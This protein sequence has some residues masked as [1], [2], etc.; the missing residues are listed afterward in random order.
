MA[1]GLW[2]LS[3]LATLRSYRSFRP[4]V[5]Y[6]WGVSQFFG[7]LWRVLREEGWPVAHN[8]EDTHV[9]RQIEQ[10]AGRWELWTKPG[11]TP[12][13]GFVKKLVRQA[14]MA[15]DSAALRPLRASEADLDHLVFCSGFI[16]DLH[17]Q[18]GLPVR[19]NRVIYNGVDL[20]VF[21][22]PHA[23]RPP[24]PLRL[25]FVG[26]S[27]E[28]KGLHVALD[29]VEFLLNKGRQIRLDIY[30]IPA[31]P[32]EYGLSLRRRVAERLAR[33]VQFHEPLQSEALA[34]VYRAHDALLFPSSRLEGL[35]MVL[36]EAMACGLPVLSTRTGGS[37][38]LVRDGE[39]ALAIAPNDPEGL[40]R[41]IER[42]DDDRE[43]LAR[44]ASAS[45]R[46]AH[47]TCD[48]DMVV[49]STEDFL[50]ELVRKRAA[51]E[52]GA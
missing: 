17:L 25:L 15:W 26:R 33:A 31:Y 6:A 37:G 42:I 51:G 46:L 9:A 52:M 41:A 19:D 32:F 3:D 28:E 4:D 30:V 39:T 45:A 47:E 10:D 8:V 18:S 36:I 1:L 43:L 34:D 49:S 12:F 5:V 11:A 50:A 7:S 13:R 44:L 22:P 48:L 27:H 40:A 14:F 29:A 23:P 38:D 24:G 2:E 35:P 20:K 16:R 21:H